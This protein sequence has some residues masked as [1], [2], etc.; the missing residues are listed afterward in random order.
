MERTTP[1]KEYIDD[2]EDGSNFGNDNRNNKHKHHHRHNKSKNL[3][4]NIKDNNINDNNIKDNNIL[5]LIIE[6]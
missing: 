3:D 2:F 4:N 1:I 6:I 5:I